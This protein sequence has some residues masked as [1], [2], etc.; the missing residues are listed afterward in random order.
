MRGPEDHTGL[1]LTFPADFLV[2]SPAILPHLSLSV[3]MPAQ[4]GVLGPPSP[5]FSLGRVDV[6]LHS[7]K[8]FECCGSL[9]SLISLTLLSLKYSLPWLLRPF[10]FQVPALFLPSTVP[11]L[12]PQ[13]SQQTR[14][15]RLLVHL[16]SG[17]LDPDVPRALEIAHI[18]N[19]NVFP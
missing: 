5:C 12:S 14:L 13:C 15:D 18:M 16:F 4:R 9:F 3:H 11:G 6:C 1:S 2:V 17:P 8:C 10:L 7:A 19:L